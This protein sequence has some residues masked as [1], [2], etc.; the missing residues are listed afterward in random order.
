MLSER[1]TTCSKCGKK[2]PEVLSFTIG[3]EVLC[4]LCKPD[5]VGKHLWEAKHP[6]YCSD[7]CYFSAKAIVD[8]YGTWQEFVEASKDDDFDLNLLFRWDWNLGEE[9]DL[10]IHTDPYYRD[11]ELDL[12]FMLQ[13][14]GYHRVARISVCKADED[15]VRVWLN[16]RWEH[17]Q[18]LWKPCSL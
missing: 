15:L 2:P 16:L 10:P 13:R 3:D 17:M 6:Y 8:T 9:H 18:T 4:S 7:Q 1:F 5:S 12:F 11:G 14:K